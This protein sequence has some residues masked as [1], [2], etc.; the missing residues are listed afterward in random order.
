[1][2]V[3][4]LDFSLSQ[5]CI[6][7]KVCDYTA[8]CLC[9]W[10]LCF[11]SVLRI[12]SSEGMC[13]SSATPRGRNQ[14]VEKGVPKSVCS[15]RQVSEFVTS[16]APCCCLVLIQR[17]ITAAELVECSLSVHICPLYY[18]YNIL[19]RTYVELKTFVA[20]RSWPVWHQPYQLRGCC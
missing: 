16:E 14:K 13:A 20:T 1:M 15:P 19:Q 10:L 17:K 3:L 7:N 8:D 5:L 6:R 2:P 9:S 11:F 18:L 4:W 12:I